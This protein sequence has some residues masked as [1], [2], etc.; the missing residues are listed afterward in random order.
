MFFLF[1]VNFS[2]SVCCEEVLLTIYVLRELLY[3]WKVVIDNASHKFKK[4]IGV[5]CHFMRINIQFIWLILAV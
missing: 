4:G 5:K 2:K 1:L 3:F